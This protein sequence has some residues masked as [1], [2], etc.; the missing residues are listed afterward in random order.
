MLKR[1]LVQ[2]LPEC[3]DVK[4]HEATSALPDNAV[5]EEAAFVLT[6]VVSSDAHALGYLRDPAGARIEQKTEGGKS[7]V[8]FPILTDL[9]LCEI[10]NSEQ[11]AILCTSS[12]KLNRR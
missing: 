8:L 6:C 3:G 9:G 1:L 11:E 10:M 2:E 5:F 7:G 12:A 4:A